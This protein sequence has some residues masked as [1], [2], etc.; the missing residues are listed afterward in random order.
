MKTLIQT[1][2]DSKIRSGSS[3]SQNR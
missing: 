2:P 3:S 1:V